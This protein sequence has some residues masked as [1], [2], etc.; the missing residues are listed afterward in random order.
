MPSLDRFFRALSV[1]T[2]AA[3]AACG[4][5]GGGG[6][7]GGPN[8]GTPILDAEF[9]VVSGPSGTIAGLNVPVKLIFNRAV[10]PSSVDAAAIQVVTVNDP[11]GQATASPGL[12][13]DVIFSVQ[14]KVVTLTPIVEFAPTEVTFGFV[15]DALYEISFSP[16]ASGSVVTSKEGE[17]LPNN[18]PSYF[19]RTATGAFDFEPGFP[20]PTLVFVDDVDTVVL[21]DAVDDTDGDGTPVDETIA[22]FPGATIITDGM[23]I[24]ATP[25]TEILFL[26]DDALTPSS[27]LNALDGTSPTLSVS[28]NTAPAPTFA[29][30]GVSNDLSFLL[31]QPDMTVLRW[32]PL[33]S[34]YPPGGFLFLMVSAN[35]A[36]LAGNSKQSIT[37]DGTPSIDYTLLVSGAPDATIYQVFEPFDTSD[38]EDPATSSAEWD[39][40]F[41]GQLGPVFGGGT[42][43]DGPLV[44]DATGTAAAPGTTVVPPGATIDFPDKLVQ[45]PTV[46]E[47]APGVLEPRVYDFTRL[48]L[49]TGWT[50][51]PLTDRDDDG[52]PDV[53]EFQ[54]ASPGHPLDGLGAPLQI[55]C[56]GDAEVFGIIDGRGVSAVDITRPL[57]TSDPGYAAYRGQGG[58]GAATLLAAGDGGDGGDVLMLAQDGDTIALPL[59]SPTNGPGPGYE[60]SDGRLL[61]V[62][63]RSASRTSTTL[64][65]SGTDLSVLDPDSPMADPGLV[66]LLAA[67][68]LRLQPNVGVGSQAFGSS[69]TKNESI[70]ENHPT[71]VVE[72]VAFTGGATSTITVTSGPGDP[73]LDMIS[74]NLSLEPISS[75]LDCYLI[76]RLAGRAGEDAATLERGGNGSEPYVVVNDVIITTTSGGGGG[77]GGFLPGDDGESSGPASDPSTTQRNQ[78]LGGMALEDSPGAPGGAGAIR[79]TATV[80]DGETLAL[81]TQ[82]E[83]ADLAALA[84]PALVGAL[85]IPNAGNDGWLFEIDAFDGTTF[86]LRGIQTDALDIDLVDADGPDLSPTVTYPFVIVPPLEFGGA[87]GGGSGVAVT[88][89]V[90]TS[91]SDLPTLDPGGAGGAGGTSVFLEAARRVVLGAQSRVLTEGGAGATVI[92]NTQLSGG[93]G[94]GGGSAVVRVGRTLQLFAGALVSSQGGEGGGTTGFGQGGR[95]GAGYIRFENFDDDL[96]PTQVSVVTDPDVDETNLGRFLGDPQGVGQSLFYSTML[97]NPEY[98]AVT[99]TYVAD[100]TDT[101]TMTTEVGKVLTWRFDDGGITATDDLIDPPFRIRFNGVGPN[102]AGLLDTTAIVNDFYSP[103]DLL[104]ARSDL[105]H[106]ALKGIVYA[107]PG[108]ETTLISRLDEATL[109]PLVPPTLAL[110]VIPSNGTTELDVLSIA[111]DAANDEILLLER[112]TRRMHVIDGTSGAF[113]RTIT[114]PISPLGAIAYDP[115]TELVLVADNANNQIVGFPTIDTTATTSF[116]AT[117]FSAQFDLRRDGV[118]LETEFTG[119]AV[120]AATNRLWAVDAITGLLIEFD[121]AVGLEGSSLSSTHVATVLR[122]ATSGVVASGLAHTGTDLVLTHCVDPF[123]CRVFTLDPTTL[124]DDGSETLLASFGT[125]LPQIA[126]SILDGDQFIRFRIVLDGVKNATDGAFYVLADGPIEFRSV[127]IEAISI[128][129]VNKAF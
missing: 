69:G 16:A 81:E 41:P 21:P 42:G 34:A 83:G 18:A 53:E 70:D 49:P 59:K 40:A 100:V 10:A 93:G 6:S 127:R 38:Q 2:F 12:T 124:P 79:G 29:P 52:T 55:R 94:G 24:P 45:L 8:A 80:L 113:L 27:V 99:V 117:G 75:G 9:Q 92:S 112:A 14:G 122:T 76:G 46:I 50:L 48:L 78:G 123:D 72:D 35:V 84:G 114:L 103:A 60:A 36:D 58:R 32:T 73:T 4:G 129:L 26:F 118:R 108:E 57:S 31:Q 95:G 98:E 120:D 65:D 56:S 101:T 17:A 85:F 104:S 77:G 3:L 87:G 37:G 62:T 25:T 13:A 28:V 22:L 96:D 102:T 63:G 33:L 7:G 19:F 119:M 68:E 111:V 1:P 51:R 107:V 91:P 54:V 88:G 5:G 20:L 106:D 116:E 115:T 39:S 67:G 109:Q 74:E 97:A 71:F 23:M 90:N 128:E 105:A 15:E 126:E 61:G 86:T 30:S 47:V 110:P 43:A 11:A 125:L 64:T 82:T 44:V 121:L 89:T 66:A